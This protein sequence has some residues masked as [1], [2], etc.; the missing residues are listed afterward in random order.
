MVGPGFEVVPLSFGERSRLYL[1]VLE[2]SETWEKSQ[3]S[4]TDA[5][6]SSGGNETKNERA[7]NKRSTDKAA[8]TRAE[9]KREREN[10]GKATTRRFDEGIE[11]S[12]TPLDE[13]TAAQKKK[14]GRGRSNERPE[15]PA[16]G[17]PAAD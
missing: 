4:Q 1:P 2:N 7:A 5:A 10:K 14:D 3:V 13:G 15:G 6:S 16:H 17:C 11:R 8:E 12:S 9:S